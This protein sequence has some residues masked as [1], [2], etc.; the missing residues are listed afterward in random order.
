MVQHMLYLCSLFAYNDM[1]MPYNQL[2][3]LMLLVTR[4]V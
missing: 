4:F 3:A 1:L 2:L